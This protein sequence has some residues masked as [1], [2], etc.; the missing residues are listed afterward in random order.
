MEREAED[1][2]NPLSQQG[3]ATLDEF[4]KA[5]SNECDDEDVID[6]M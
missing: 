1:I 6:V 4:T 2:L 3:L 5:D